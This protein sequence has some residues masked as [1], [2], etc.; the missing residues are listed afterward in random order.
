MNLIFS[1]QNKIKANFIRRIQLKM[2]LSNK[3]YALHSHIKMQSFK[4]KNNFDK[5]KYADSMLCFA[6][7]EFETLVTINQQT[8]QSQKYG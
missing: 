5:Y 3:I 4:E 8:F 7:F 6:F 1:Q 2:N